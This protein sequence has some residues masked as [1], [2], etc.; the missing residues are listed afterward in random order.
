[1]GQE[2]LFWI[3]VGIFVV[4][5]GERTTRANEAVDPD[6]PD[7]DGVLVLSKQN[8]DLAISKYKFL[9]VE[10]CMFEMYLALY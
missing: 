5:C 3:A 7:D 10:F 4:F 8:F 2:A 1:M 6:I 9:L